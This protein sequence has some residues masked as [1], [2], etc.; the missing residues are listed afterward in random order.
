MTAEQGF[1]LHPL[2][3]RDITE[4]WKYIAEDNPLA[5]RRVAAIT[6][7]LRR[8]WMTATTLFFRRVGNQVFTYENEAKRP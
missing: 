6:R 8:P 3:A 7:G 2:A 5:A 1:R 4:I